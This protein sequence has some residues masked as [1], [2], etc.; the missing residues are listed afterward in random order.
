M[1]NSSFG[2]IAS[3][4]FSPAKTF[5]SIAERPTW[6]VAL[7]ALFAVSLASMLIAVPKIDWQETVRSEIAKSGQN[8]PPDQ[9]DNQAELMEKFGA[10]FIYVT[11][12]VT[13]WIFYPLLAAIF[14]GVFRLFGREMH[15]KTSLAVAVHGFMPWLVATL[16][17]LPVLFS[18]GDVTAEQLEQ[19][20][21]A[22]HLAAFAGDDT[23]PTL[24]AFLAS[25]DFFSLWTIVM[26]TIGYSIAA[27]I[28]RG[29]A[30]ACVVGVWL[31]YV[32]GKVGL[33]GLGQ[34]LAG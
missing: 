24:A 11:T 27:G 9:I 12:V 29:R 30:A 5:Q 33:T 26:L 28:S 14:L 22:S 32:A 6:L 16:L 2:R 20:V 18:T 25:I 34:M 10:T 31:V 23:S 17:G 13:P 3:V 4:L 1:E 15:F 7:L 19:G 8:L 21:L